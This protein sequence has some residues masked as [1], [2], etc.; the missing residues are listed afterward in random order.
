VSGRALR[1]ASQQRALLALLK[2]RPFAAGDDPYLDSVRSS[3]G[4][5]TQRMIAGWWRRFDVERL[6]PLTSRALSHA[7]RFEDALTR[8]G[9]DP[10]TPSGMGAVAM[11]FLMQHVEDDDPLIAAVASTERALTLVSRGDRSRHEVSWDRDPAPSLG[12]L[13]A[14]R[15]PERGAPGAFRVSVSGDLPALIAVERIS[16]SPAVSTSGD[17]DAA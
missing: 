2:D 1:L 4:L 12:A 9:R 3:K 6:A 7:G 17:G 8:L 15:P 13:L 14:G 16:G 10:D 11:H 5:T